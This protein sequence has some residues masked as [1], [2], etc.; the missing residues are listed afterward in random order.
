MQTPA[1]APPP[2]PGP[3]MVITTRDGATQV[4]LNPPMTAR[5]L[6]AL[7]NRREGL[8][9]QLLS[10]QDRRK[11]VAEALKAADP[12]ARPGLQ[13]RLAVLDERIVQLERDIASTGRELTSAPAGLAAVAENPMRPD[14]SDGPAFGV[15]LLAGLALATIYSWARRLGH[16]RGARSREAVSGLQAGQLERLEQSIDA[17]AVEVERISEGQRFTT[18]L[19]AERAGSPPLLAARGTDDNDS[20]GGGSHAQ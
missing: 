9:N 17:I 8:S 19:F 13:E 11:D 16:P 1:V 20:R 3:G 12:A 6:R 10:V 18:R 14:T 5:D 15:G 4:V 2:P 7:Q